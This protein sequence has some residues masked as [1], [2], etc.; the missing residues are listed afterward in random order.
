[1]TTQQTAFITG[2]SGYIAKHAVLRFLNAG[3]L[4]RGSTRS[5]NRAAEVRDAVA[6]GV[7]ANVDLDASLSFVTLDLS[8][9]QGW[10]DALSGVD[11]LVHMAS[12][13]PIAQPKN[14]EELIRPAVDGTLRALRAAKANGV[15]RVVLTSSV[16]AITGSEPS[17]GSAFTEADWTDVDHPTSSPYSVSKTLAER[18]AWDFVTNDAPEMSLTVINPGFVLGAPLD[19]NYGSS[20]E[21]IERV[22][23]AKDPAVPD[24]S[25]TTVDVGDVAE[26]HL[27]AVQRPES[28]GER[29]AAAARVMTFLEIAETIKAQYPDRKVVTR[30]APTWLMKAI[31]LV[32]KEVRAIVP[33]LGR[34]DPVLNDK[35]TAMLE[36]DFLDPAESVRSSA[37]Y[38]IDNGL[39]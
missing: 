35:A 15:T 17:S 20:I 32:D 3:F 25:F 38:L 6:D 39:A 23:R 28:G 4:V 34:H 7:S 12:P 29:I 33:S 13:F 22:L 30:L 2:A 24:L 1:M 21:T 10:D 27:R 36:M 31:A 8:S 18:A 11:V 9:D 16:V 14:P 37:A 5:P 19:S 26:M